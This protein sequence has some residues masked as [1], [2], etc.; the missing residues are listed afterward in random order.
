MQLTDLL[1]QTGGTAAIARELG[2]SETQAASG[3]AALLPSILG[4]LQ[5][6]AAGA[7]PA[8]GLGGLLGAL[9]GGGLLEQVLSHQPT[10]TAPGNELLGHIF[11]D[12]DT[13]RAVAQNAAATSGLDPTILKK[14]LPILA[15]LVGGYL[16]KHGSS[17]GSP[18]GLGGVLG[19]LAGALGGGG[20]A[21]GANPLNDLLGRLGR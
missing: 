17:T 16:A 14:M 11:G 12:K 2:L 19:N 9:G 7:H 5:N 4:G 13:S 10:N 8:G 3:A 18:G 1:N 15:M 21:T 6:P 20:G